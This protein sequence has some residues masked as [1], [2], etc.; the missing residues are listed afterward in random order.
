[1]PFKPKF[2]HAATPPASSDPAPAAPSMPTGAA[3]PAGN[4]GEGHTA[5]E[6]APAGEPGGPDHTTRTVASSGPGEDD[7]ESL[8]TDPEPA[9]ATAR[10]SSSVSEAV[11][12]TH[13]PF[14]L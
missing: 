6:A 13:S 4:A 1:M 8:W 2:E 5:P 14:S 9:M 7:W 3:S 12:E 11:F 10:M